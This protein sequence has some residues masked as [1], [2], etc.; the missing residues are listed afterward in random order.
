M[1]QHVHVK[2]CMRVLNKDG[3]L[4]LCLVFFFFINPNVINRKLNG[5]TEYNNLLLCHN[6]IRRKELHCTPFILFLLLSL[7]FLIL[8]FTIYFIQH[9]S[10]TNESK[11]H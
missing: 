5:I 10:K 8:C 1:L 7:L 11:Q 3:E 9:I 4:V 2:T 6:N